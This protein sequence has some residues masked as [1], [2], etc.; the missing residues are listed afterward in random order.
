M[1]RIRQ[2][3]NERLADD[4][5]RAGE[6]LAFHM[7]VQLY[8][9]VASACNIDCFMCEEHNRPPH[10]RRGHGLMSM[11]PEIYE[12]L[13][14]EVFPYSSAVMF[15]VGGEPMISR[16][17]LDFVERAHRHEQRIEVT[18][19]GTR[20]HTDEAAETVARCVDNLTV[21]IDAARPET[22]EKIRLGSKW[23][24]LRSNLDRLNRFR[25]ASAP[26]PRTHLQLN[27]VLMRCNVD[28]LPAFVELAAEVEADHVFAQHLIVVTDDA[29]GESLFDEPER[30]DA[31]RTAAL[32]TAARLGISVDLPAP[33]R[34]AAERGVAPHGRSGTGCDAPTSA[35]PSSRI[36]C[37]MPHKTAFVFYDG[38]VYPCC[39]PY[40]HRCMQ[41]G[42]LATQSF[43]EIWN[44]K[45]YRN[46]RAGMGDGDA[47]HICRSCSLIHDPPPEPENPDVLSREENA[48]DAH[49]G[50]RDRAPILLAGR[51]VDRLLASSPT[52]DAGATPPGEQDDGSPAIAN[53]LTARITEL[54]AERSTLVEHIANVDA[55]RRTERAHIDNLEADAQRHQTE[56]ARVEGE[57]REL[58]DALDRFRRNPVVRLGRWSR[59]LTARGRTAGRG[60]DPLD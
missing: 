18:T 42:D 2:Q 37:H 31:A 41:M 59:N 51:A 35:T 40:A 52:A 11:A 12:K 56:V 6:G 36:P 58:K 16:D 5:L 45:R 20:L 8:L 50:D 15:G 22:Y 21:S 33:Y 32:E 38:R 9:Q 7:P 24:R 14:T 39:H 29:R 48:I 3:M 46:L 43:D 49:Y 44:G 25:L 54:E 47:P 60:A 34:S 28:E 27:F 26:G 1:T 57:I 13:E 17:F 30:Y 23:T 53:D 55:V 10:L 19:N 4:A